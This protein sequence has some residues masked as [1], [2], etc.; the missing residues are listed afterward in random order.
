MQPCVVLIC[1][2]SND[3]K[4]LRFFALKNPDSCH[5]GPTSVCRTRHSH[6][7]TGADPAPHNLP[8]PPN[9]VCVFIKG[10]HVLPKPLLDT[11][12]PPLPPPPP[13]P[14]PVDSSGPMNTPHSHHHP[15]GSMVGHPSVISSSRPMHGASMSGLGSPMNGLTSAYS[16]I[17]SS[18]GSPSASLPSTPTMNFGTLSSPQVGGQDRPLYRRLRRVIWQKKT[19][20][21]ET[22][23]QMCILQHLHDD[24]LQG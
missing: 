3:L 5:A 9:V 15:M 16:V 4:V 10:F 1:A 13:P 14:P 17:T 22:I 7:R 6:G 2:S 21:H 23:F 8:P 19:K 12:P 18:L 20:K 24:A 11:P